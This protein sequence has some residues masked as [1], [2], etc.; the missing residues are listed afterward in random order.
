MSPKQM[1]EMC[2]GAMQSRKPQEELI[3]GC[4][5]ADLI[6]EGVRVHDQVPL[7]RPLHKAELWLHCDA[8]LSAG[9]P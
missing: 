2:K 4:W 3:I 7:M 1:T 8:P 9:I 5:K 6:P